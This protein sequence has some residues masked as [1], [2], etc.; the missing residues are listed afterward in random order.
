MEV[1]IEMGSEINKFG[2]LMVVVG[3]HIGR[4]A[5]CFTLK[6]KAID[7]QADDCEY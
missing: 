6:T 4:L 2:Y 5:S 3:E 1:V 7:K